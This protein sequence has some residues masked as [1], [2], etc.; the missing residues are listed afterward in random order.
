MRAAIFLSAGLLATSLASA[1]TLE[2]EAKIPLPG[3]QGRIDHLCFDD[4]RRRLF[5]AELGNGSVAVLD[6]DHHRLERR[7]TG[8]EEPQGVACFAPQHRLYVAEGGGTVRAYDSATLEPVATTKLGDD[9][10]NLRIDRVRARLVVG[11]G[12]ALALLDAGTLKRI[13][14]IPLKAHPESFQLSPRDGLV[15][16]NVPRAQEIAVIDLGQARQVGAWPLTKWSSNYPMAL[17]DD[18]NSALSVFRRPARIARFTTSNG[19]MTADVE[20]CG[21][22]DDVFVDEK[23]DRVYVICGEGVVDVLD[24]KTLRRIERFPTIAGART[25]LWT[26]GDFLFVAARSTGHDDAAVW[27]LK[28]AK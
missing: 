25:G 6:F 22:A 1:A 14:N 2:L 24:R 10:D 27:I 15:Y 9:A 18:G 20:T 5:V 4:E 11:Y 8:L 19:S 16:V 17:D 28:P 26:T 7:L 23:R 13:A 12:E 3:S 21:D